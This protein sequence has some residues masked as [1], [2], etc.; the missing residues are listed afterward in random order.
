MAT[1]YVVL[2]ITKVTFFKN[3]QVI[4]ITQLYPELVIGRLNIKL[5]MIVWYRI[6]GDKIGCIDLYNRCRLV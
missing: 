6:R 1:I 3:L 2:P 4:N 5:I